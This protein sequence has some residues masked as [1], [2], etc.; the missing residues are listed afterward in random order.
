MS[1]IGK[2]DEASLN[3]KLFSKVDIEQI[4]EATLEVLE[5]TGVQAPGKE[6]HQYYREAG[7]IVD[8]ETGIVKIPRE[9]AIR[10]LE[11]CPS[12]FML[13]G[14]DPKNNI[15]FGDGTVRYTN[16]GTAVFIK[17]IETGELREST[18]QDVADVARFVDGLPE[19]D[20]F[21]IPVTAGDVDQEYKNL[22]EGEAVLL[23]TTKHFAHHN[24]SGKNTRRWI[25]MCATIVGGKEELRK[26]PITTTVACPTSPLEIAENVGDI[27]IESAKAGLPIDVLSMGLSGGTTPVT[28]VGT[29]VVTNSEFIAAVVLAQTVNPGNP[30]IMGTSSTIMDLRLATSPV[31]SPEM[32]MLGV[33]VSQIGQFYG[34]PT[35]CGGT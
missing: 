18:K 26:H 6:V 25:E 7:C 23:N 12:E 1:K 14:R 15:L 19:I 31:G 10:C 35:D 27:I 20:I 33:G 17:D 5:T 21:H 24:D 8:D 2:F 34:I 32:A 29:L 4:H 13:Y 22:H 28:L 30:I 9:I 11:Q 16:F 3:Y